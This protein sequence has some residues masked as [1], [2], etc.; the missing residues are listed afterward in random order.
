[1]RLSPRAGKAFLLQQPAALG[2]GEDEV[3]CEEL[4]AL[5]QKLQQLK[6]RSAHRQV[7]QGLP[8]A[9]QSTASA[10][11]DVSSSAN[12]LPAT[13]AEF[14]Q[15][16]QCSSSAEDPKPPQPLTSMS[17]DQ[18]QQ[19]RISLERKLVELLQRHNSG[20]QEAQQAALEREEEPAVAGVAAG[21]RSDPGVLSIVKSVLTSTGQGCKEVV[22]RDSNAALPKGVSWTTRYIEFLR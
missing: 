13:V 18:K 6:S 14:Q 12:P 11:L 20:G 4:G 8:M 2:V 22:L 16:Q 17:A 21:L 3:I 5:D 7:R 15:R 1:V 19:I 9:L 10:P